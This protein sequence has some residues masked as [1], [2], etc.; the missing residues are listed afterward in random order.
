MT[1]ATALSVDR[2]TQ[3][4][5]RA[6][7][8]DFVRHSALVFGASMAANVLNYV[9]NFAISRNVGVEG[10]ATL[11]SLVSFLMLLS[12]PTSILSLVVV[13]YAA[14]YHAAGDAARVRRL[15]QV[16]LKW[17]G[18]AAVGLF[19]IGV[20]LRPEIASF[21]HIDDDAAIVLCLGII[22]LGLITPS[23]RSILQGEQDFLRYGISTVLEVFLKVLIAIALVYAGYGV[24]GAML[25]WII[26]TACA[27]AY[28]VWAVLSKHGAASVQPVR[29][30]LDVRRLLH[31]T[32]GVGLATGCLTVMSFMD[33]LLVKHFFN[34]HEAGLYAAVNLTGKVV[35][36]V[37][38]FVPAVVLP[39]AIAKNANGE[40]PV[41]LLAQAACLTA[42]M[43]GGV[44]L[45]FG[46]LPH[47]IVRVLAGR[48]FLAAAPYVL[49]YD[50]AMCLLALLT[51]LINYLIGIHRFQFLYG[52]G[53]V[54]AAEVTAVAL[55]HTT[56]WDVIHVLL[57]GNACA[58]LACCSVLLRRG[59]SN[60]VAISPTE[61][62]P[63]A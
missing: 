60:A 46:A 33:V 39:K 54:L 20:L 61:A 41:P 63:N 52:L 25:G 45:V 47:E 57:I 4:V 36:F 7:R 53:A 50:A 8:N 18:I 40:N 56:L 32:L 15:S 59:V 19:A 16:L 27:V 44:L 55:F 24:A 51:L 31:T 30:G 3:P 14:A 11:S 17:S 10:F 12:I 1:A 35:F 21:L 62:F 37:V 49:Q 48:A 2:L 6:L 34:A 26:G 22:G 13:K 28:T 29:L 43:S 42:V 23:V 9:F 58:I 38:G 5:K